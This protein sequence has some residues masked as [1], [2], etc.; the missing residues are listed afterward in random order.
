ML[1][2]PASRSDADRIFKA[3]SNLEDFRCGKVR[4][5]DH[6]EL[7]EWAEDP[8][9]VLLVATD[10]ADPQDVW[11]F[12]FAKK[13]SSQWYMLDCVYVRPEHRRRQV[14]SALLAVLVGIMRDRN[15]PYV[16]C[17][18]E[19][20]EVGK[21]LGAINWESGAGYRWYERWLGQRRECV[22]PDGKEA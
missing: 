15:V 11:G 20:S 6:S 17:L 7:A 19:S 1:I 13:I 8:S 9:A 2:K 16:S 18:T 10:A 3:F 22:G 4:F 14:G 5:Y 12:L 21:W